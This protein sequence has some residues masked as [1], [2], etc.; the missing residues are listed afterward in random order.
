MLMSVAVLPEPEPDEDAVKLFVERLG[1]PMDAA[2]KLSAEGHTSI[3]EIAYVPVQELLESGV[4]ADV[5]E[6]IRAR[7]REL[8]E[9]L[10]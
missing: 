6:K 4:D 7:A 9:Q 8:L 1:A 10:P 3:E 5:L 2:R